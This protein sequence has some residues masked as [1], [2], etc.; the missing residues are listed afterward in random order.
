MSQSDDD[1]SVRESQ[2]DANSATVPSRP[3]RVDV[4]YLKDLAG[5][6]TRV[7]DFDSGRGDVKLIV[8]TESDE[9]ISDLEAFI[10]SSSAMM[11]ASKPWE[12]MLAGPFGEGQPG[13]PKIIDFTEDDSAAL[14]VVMDVIHL[15]FDKLPECLSLHDLAELAILADR[16]MLAAILK[17]WVKDWIK[18]LYP[19]IT[20]QGKERHWLWVSFVYDLTEIFDQVSHRLVM[21]SAVVDVVDPSQEEP[22]C[23]PEDQAPERGMQALAYPAVE[24]DDDLS[25]LDILPPGVEAAVLAKR[26][27]IITNTLELVYS[28]FNKLQ[29]KAGSVFP[30][31]ANSKPPL[32]GDEDLLNLCQ[33]RRRDCLLLQ[34]GSLYF[35]LETLGLRP[36]KDSKDINISPT[37]LQKSIKSIRISDCKSFTLGYSEN[38][39]YCSSTTII[40]DTCGTFASILRQMKA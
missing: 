20:E 30:T 37:E 19:T 34:F 3:G 29:V 4:G 26:H 35:A 15:R 22:D 21:E 10:V 7:V 18:D 28:Y 38:H 12:R 11:R 39:Y 24:G 6:V 1:V 17:P 5:R 32:H 2:T 31:T 33:Y 40:R 9:G 36:E 13:H 16:Y 27:E 23:S 25:T 14:K 8:R